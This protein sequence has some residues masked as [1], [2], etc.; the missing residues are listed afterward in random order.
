MPWSMVFSWNSVL[1]FARIAVE[2]L[3]IAFVIYKILYYLRG[4]RAVNVLAGLVVGGLSLYLIADFLEF[5]VVSW[6][7]DG[8]MSL[9]AF[10]IFVLFQP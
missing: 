1:D 8:F 9:M 7:L 5:T 2:F 4:T 10:T 3:L 6:L